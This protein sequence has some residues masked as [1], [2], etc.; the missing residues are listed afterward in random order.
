MPGT[1]PVPVL[2]VG[3]Q[4]SGKTTTAGKIALRL[5]KREKKRVLMASLDVYRPAAQHQLAV[6]GEQTETPVMTVEAGEKPVEIAVKTSALQT[7]ENRTVVFVRSGEKF[8]ARDVELGARDG[9]MVEI[10]V[11]LALE[12][13]AC[14]RRHAPPESR[15]ACR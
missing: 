6:L 8:E 10:P 11:D 2:L 7:M 1:P 3:L 5:R 13:S 15:R 14:A 4:G 9:E 12:L